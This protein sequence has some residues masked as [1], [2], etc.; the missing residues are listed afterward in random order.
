[1]HVCAWVCLN[2]RVIP[3]YALGQSQQSKNENLKRKI[4]Y[5]AT[6]SAGDT[7]PD[8]SVNMTAGGSEHGIETAVRRRRELFEV[9]MSLIY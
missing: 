9:Q 3:G 6:T 8:I 4:K 1:M 7:N 5:L 2:G